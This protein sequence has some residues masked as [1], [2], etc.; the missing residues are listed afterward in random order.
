MKE[1]KIKKIF[2]LLI[3]LI[4][5]V[6]IGV[7]L[8]RQKIASFEAEKLAK[9]NE[10]AGKDANSNLGKSVRIL[11]V[12]DMM[13]D[14]YIRQ[15]AEKKGSD[16]IFAGAIKILS[17]NDLV[18]GNL[19]GPITDK[20]SVS[21]GSEIGA[22]DNYIFTFSPSI[23]A[24]LWKNNIKLVSIGN[25]HILNFG[26][27]GLAQTKENLRSSKIDFFGDP[28]GEKRITTWRKDGLKL[29]FVSFNQ[30]E[31]DGSAKTMNDIA[32]AKQMNVDII[33]LYAHWGKEFMAEPEATIKELAPRFVDGGADLIIGSHPHVVQGKE[34][35]QGKMIYYSLGNFIFDQYFSP[36]TQKG[37]AVQLEINSKDKKIISR[38]FS[39]VMKAA[40]QTV[41]IN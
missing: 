23:A 3:L 18:V 5:L 4:S 38:E 6:L 17:E 26:A 9:E 41:V 24:D 21:V 1:G 35:Y 2:P 19:E 14:R 12:G 39:V 37:L 15:I 16:S 30:F 40:G 27:G 8:V 34:Q 28:A 32:S 36:E 13:F 20:P 29:A 7:F 11:F 33:I 31:K 22:H 10:Q 25:N